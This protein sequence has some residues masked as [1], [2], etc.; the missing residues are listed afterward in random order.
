MTTLRVV[1][2]LLA[3]VLAGLAAAQPAGGP[4]VVPRQTIDAGG[5][6]VVGAVGGY[7]LRG[8]LGQP[9]AGPAHTSATFTL[10][11]GFQRAAGESLPIDAMF[12][13]GFEPQSR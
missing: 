12:A 10:R 2:A 1:G 6:I 8:S 7:T 4:Y 3:S 11:G 9:D 5:R 13:D